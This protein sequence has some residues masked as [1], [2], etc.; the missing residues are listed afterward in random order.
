MFTAC[1]LS[2]REAI[3]PV[4]SQSTGKHRIWSAPVDWLTW[5][6]IY[7]CTGSSGESDFSCLEEAVWTALLLLKFFVYKNTNILERLSLVS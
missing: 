5:R 1:T 4:L 6:L 3:A 7:S 2:T